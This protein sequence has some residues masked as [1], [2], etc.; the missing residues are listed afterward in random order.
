MDRAIAI[1]SRCGTLEPLSKNQAVRFFDVDAGLCAHVAGVRLSGNSRAAQNHYRYGSRHGRC[2]GDHAGAKFAGIGCARIYGG[3]GKCYG[4][5]RLGECTPDG[6]TGEPLRYSGCG[7]SA[8]SIV[9]KTDYGRILAREK[10]SGE[11]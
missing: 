2:D 7:R 5:A 3:A 10:W 1:V 6:L 8:A 11:Q 4:S 9:P